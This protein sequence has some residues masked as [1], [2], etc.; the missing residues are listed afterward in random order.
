MF[1]HPSWPQSSHQ[2]DI[3]APWALWPQ[4]N[5]FHDVLGA[6]S[7]VVHHADASNLWISVGSGG[8]RSHDSVLLVSKQT[9]KPSWSCIDL[10]VQSLGLALPLFPHRCYSHASAALLETEHCGSTE[11]E[12]ASGEEE[13][14]SSTFMIRKYF[15]HHITNCWGYHRSQ[16]IKTLQDACMDNGTRKVTVNS[17]NG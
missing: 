17:V 14:K 8:T 6:E 12:F 4:T 2:Q 7:T 9:G 5:T 11:G 3:I 13:A 10:G 1:G 15:D 16:Q